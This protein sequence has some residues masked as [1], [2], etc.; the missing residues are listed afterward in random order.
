MNQRPWKGNA[1]QQP[2][3]AAFTSSCIHQHA[4]TS[5]HS[6]I[7]SLKSS[8]SLLFCC[9]FVCFLLVRIFTQKQTTVM[10]NQLSFAS[11]SS[12]VLGY[13]FSAKKTMFQRLFF[14]LIVFL[15]QASCIFE[16]SS[17]LKV[18]NSCQTYNMSLCVCPLFWNRGSLST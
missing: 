3:F 6:F 16:I 7:L 13:I 8:D 10:M 17:A 12:F 15:F 2:T 9:F 11:S 1:Q 4:R 18:S 14:L 5:V